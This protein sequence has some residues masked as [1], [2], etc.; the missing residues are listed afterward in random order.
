MRGDGSACRSYLYG[1]DLAVWLWGV[2]LLGTSGRA[3]NIGSEAAVSIGELAAEV[4]AL[5]SGGGCAVQIQEPPVPGKLPER[6]VPSTQRAQKELGLKQ[7]FP[8]REA[9]QRMLECKG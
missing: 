4:A 9:L 2:L 6:Y 5:A 3:Y 8:L 1:S 7:V